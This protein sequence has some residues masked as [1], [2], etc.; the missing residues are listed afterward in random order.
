MGSFGH[1]STFSFYPAHQITT[2]E[3]GAVLTS[4]PLL[5]K[6][7]RSFRDWGRD[8]WCP[9]GKDNTCGKRFSWKLGK[10]PL[11][12]DHKYIYS[13]A[14]FNLKMTDI[15]AA[16]GLAQMDKLED[17]VKRRRENF[18]YLQ[19]RFTEEKIDSQFVMPKETCGAEACWFGF[20][21]TI[22]N[23]KI[24]RTKLMERLNA[25]GVGT[26]FVFGGN[27]TKQPYFITN[28]VPHRISGSLVNTDIIMNRAFWIGVYPALEKEHLDYAVNQMKSALL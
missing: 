14:G 11:G 2:G 7:A 19:K 26:R 4:N 3:G 18:A 21:L 22:K 20:P 6:I 17:F 8:C 12:Y 25:A 5:Y 10:L 24:D 16:I 23:D 15:Q 28:K 27:I 9:T 13:E 1:L